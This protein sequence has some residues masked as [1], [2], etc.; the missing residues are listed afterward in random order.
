MAYGCCAAGADKVDALEDGSETFLWQWELRDAK[1]LPKAQRHAAAQHKKHMH[2]VRS[3]RPRPYC[4]ILG[5]VPAGSQS[6]NTDPHGSAILRGLP[7]RTG[8]ACD[9]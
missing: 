7:W 1:L 3:G 2:K 6:A 8:I 5:S 9:K 4:H